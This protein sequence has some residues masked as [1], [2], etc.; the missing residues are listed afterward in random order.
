MA[1]GQNIQPRDATLTNDEL[2][3]NSIANPGVLNLYA[4]NV[5]RGEGN[6]E[7]V[8]QV[9]AQLDKYLRLGK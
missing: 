9:Q 8:T 7:R 4:G 2:G 5:Q 6:G 1:P 3:K